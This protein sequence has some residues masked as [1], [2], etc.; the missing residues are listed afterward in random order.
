MDERRPVSDFPAGLADPM[1]VHRYVEPER[2]V[3]GGDQLRRD[4]LVPRAMA[5]VDIGFERIPEALG[6][7]IAMATFPRAPFG[8]GRSSLRRR[9]DGA[10]WDFAAV[11][12]THD[13][14]GRALSR[15]KAW[16]RGGL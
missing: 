2:R 4:D 11:G 10:G 14:A 6:L 5:T 9:S 16:K 13:E 8:K 7:D 12:L 1:A 15:F 3:L